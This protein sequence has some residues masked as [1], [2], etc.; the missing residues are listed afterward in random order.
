MDVNIICSYFKDLMLRHLIKF[1]NYYIYIF[2]IF[3]VKKRILPIVF[4]FLLH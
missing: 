3:L 4:I 2:N 1:I